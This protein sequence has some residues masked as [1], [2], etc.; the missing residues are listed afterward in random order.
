MRPK[1]TVHDTEK[2][3]TAAF[4]SGKTMGVSGSNHVRATVVQGKTKEPVA[5]G[6]RRKEYQTPAS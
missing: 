1:T 3:N 6:V 5:S 4:E 2:A